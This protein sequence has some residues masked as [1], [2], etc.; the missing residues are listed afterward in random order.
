VIWVVT[1]SRRL[2][3]FRWLERYLPW[4]LSPVSLL[5][6]Q[7]LS[8]I[9]KLDVDPGFFKVLRSDPR[10]VLDEAP[11]ASLVDHALP[12]GWTRDPFDRLLSAHS[13]LRR[14]PLASI[15]ELILRHHPLLP[16]ELRA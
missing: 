16:P 11:L 3:R 8:E 1:R 2:S 14:I 13:Q 7:F 5:E 4:C 9:G 15:D 12:L 10:F 6:I